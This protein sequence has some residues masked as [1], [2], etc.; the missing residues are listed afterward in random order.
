LGG[1]VGEPGLRAGIHDRGRV[2]RDPVV[3]LA[4][5]VIAWLICGRSQI[6]LRCSGRPRRRRRRFE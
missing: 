2:I 5:A 1:A 4:G 3:M 6:R